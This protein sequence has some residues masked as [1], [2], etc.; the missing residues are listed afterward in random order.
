[1]TSWLTWVRSGYFFEDALLL[2][3]GEVLGVPLGQPRT[4]VTTYQEKAV[5]HYLKRV[6]LNLYNSIS[7][8]RN[9]CLSEMKAS[10]KSSNKRDQQKAVED[11]VSCCK[12]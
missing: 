6:I 11:T 10:S 3:L 7:N 5:D 4:S 1:M 2:G 9:T 8:F 12:E